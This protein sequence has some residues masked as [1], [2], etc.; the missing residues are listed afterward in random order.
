MTTENETT[1]L[2]R[3]FVAQ[4]QPH[5]DAYRAGEITYTE[6]RRQLLVLQ[7]ELGFQRWLS[8]GTNALLS[9]AGKRDALGRRVQ[10][11]LDAGHPLV[12][13]CP[14]RDELAMIAGETR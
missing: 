3:A 1:P 9:D 13:A 12:P 10:Q 5:R 8:V 6:L 4:A 14:T 11:Q 7:A 2:C